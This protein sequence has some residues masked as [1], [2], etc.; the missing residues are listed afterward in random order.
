[1][2]FLLIGQGSW[3]NNYLKT[4]SSSFPQIKLEIANRNNLK[5]LIETETFDG[6]I[7]AT[8]PDSHIEI[9]K[10]ALEH[11]L[12]CII[13]KPLAL[14]LQE[15]NQLKSF[16]LPILV[17]H[18]HLFSDAY[19]KIKQ[20]I[21]PKDIRQIETLGVCQQNLKHK[22]PALYDLGVH[23]LS[24]VLDLL[25]EDPQTIE[26]QKIN[27]HNIKLTFAQ[28]K[29][30]SIFYFAKSTF[31]QKLRELTIKGDGLEIFYD[32]QKR[33]S[34]HTPPLNNVIQVFIDAINGKEDYRLGLDLSLK[35][36]KVLEMCENGNK[37]I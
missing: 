29:T 37:I 11:T 19:Q 6:V 34:H 5:S 36:M 1:M 10:F 24:L 9:A 4:I 35:I 33:P 3:G 32:D 18:I 15:A 7:I 20:M 30:E 27:K 8:P 31:P 13:E 17:N 2:K 25:Q 28:A 12:P 26:Y 14:S 16:K 21:N 22:Y 23:D